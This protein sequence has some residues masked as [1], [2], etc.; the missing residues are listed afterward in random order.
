MRNSQW[1]DLD[2]YARSSKYKR[3]LHSRIY[4]SVTTQLHT[5]TANHSLHT[6]AEHRMQLD[7]VLFS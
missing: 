3:N 7:T 2:A 5:T 4:F 1:V 6:Q